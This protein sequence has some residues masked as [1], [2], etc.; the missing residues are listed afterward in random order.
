MNKKIFG[1]KMSR[2]RSAREALFASLIRSLVLVGKIVTT[3][4]KA[5]AINGQLGKYIHLAKKGSLGSRR[6]ILAELKND[7]KTVSSLFGKK[8]KSTKIINLPPRKGDNAQMVRIELNE[9]V[10][11]KTKRS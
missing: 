1:K 3:K 2:G 10:P 11:T 6:K 9:D 5:K 8:F 7:K 4:T